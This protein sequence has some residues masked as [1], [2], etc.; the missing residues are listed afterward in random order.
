[1]LKGEKLA[2]LPVVQ[3][4]KLPLVITSRPPRPS[5]SPPPETLLADE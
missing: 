5:A 1:M 3:A 2:D 4:S